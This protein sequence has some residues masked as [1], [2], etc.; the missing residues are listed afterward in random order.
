MMIS[1][2]SNRGRSQSLHVK[3]VLV[4]WDPGESESKVR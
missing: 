1:G 3:G 4:P 2:I